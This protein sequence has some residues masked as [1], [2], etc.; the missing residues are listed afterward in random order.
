[1]GS[2]EDRQSCRRGRYRDITHRM[3]RKIALLGFAMVG[4]AACGGEGSGSASASAASSG[5]AS[6]AAATATTAA[7]NATSTATAAAVATT[8]LTPG[9]IEE[10][11]KALLFKK[12]SGEGL[13]YAYESGKLNGE[14]TYSAYIADDEKKTGSF[15]CSLKADPKIPEKTRVTF[16]GT[17]K[18]KGWVDECT[19]AKK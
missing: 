15:K 9:K 10:N 16:E 5:Q 11:I 17:L 18:S 12:V 13:F 14:M 3:M 4:L 7:A 2:A 1:M 8:G 6:T 19:I